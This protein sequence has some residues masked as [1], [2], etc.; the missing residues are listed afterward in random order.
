MDNLH[1][2]TAL[3]G[4]LLLAAAAIDLRT[5]R[6]PNALN[7]AI[8]AAGLCATLWLNLPLGPALVGIALGYS[9]LFL[10]NQLYRHM[11]GRDGIGMGDAKLLAGAGA[12]VSWSGLPFVVLIGAALGLAF[13]AAMR[14]SGRALAAQDALA[15][16]PCLAAGTFIVW[17]VQAYAN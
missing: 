2:A 12:W 6:I 11:R 14:V 15:F 8:A 10:A 1:I 3:L 7:L 5:M 9:A 13:V 16:G 17:C 4:A